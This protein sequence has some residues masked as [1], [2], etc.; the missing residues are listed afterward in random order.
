MASTGLSLSVS[1]SRFYYSY[2]V[3]GCYVYSVELFTSFCAIIGAGFGGGGASTTEGYGSKGID[4]ASISGCGP[5]KS[6][7]FKGCSSSVS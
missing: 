7:P 4:C 2:Y 3:F 1:L 6:D 5:S